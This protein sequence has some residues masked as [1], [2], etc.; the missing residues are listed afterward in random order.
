MYYL[1][2]GDRYYS[3]L[4]AYSC[5]QFSSL[6]TAID[7]PSQDAALAVVEVLSLCGFA[8]TLRRAEIVCFEDLPIAA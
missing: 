8:R 7:F 3:G 6:K 2:L 1:K 5:P 4:N